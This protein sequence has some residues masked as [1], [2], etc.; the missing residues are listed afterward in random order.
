[1]V[2]SPQLSDVLAA[3]KG[4]TRGWTFQE[5]YP[6]RRALVFTDQQVYFICPSSS[7]FEDLYLEPTPPVTAEALVTQ[8]QTA[9]ALLHHLPKCGLPLTAESGW[10]EYQRLVER[11]IPRELTDESDNLL[12]I[13][14]LLSNLHRSSRNC[15][16]LWDIYWAFPRGS[17]LGS[18]KWN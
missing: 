15:F 4:S 7:F 18:C 5:W 12:A 3:A 14:S 9:S 6:S 11:S 13:S 17:I 1:M 16:L 10:S 8:K 2:S